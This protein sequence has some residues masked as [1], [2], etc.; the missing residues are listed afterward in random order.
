MTTNKEQKN[1]SDLL[2]ALEQLER[3][4]NIKREDVFKTITDSLVSALRKYFG[5]TAQIMAGI[6][7]ETGEMAGFLVRK[8]TDPVVTPELEISLEEAQKH[9]PDAK[10]GDDIHIPVPIQDFSRIAAQTAKQVLIQK[11]RE[12]EKVRVYDE[13]KPREGE[14][15]TGLVHHV[16][17][18]D[19]FVDLG[20]A[21]AILPFSEQI[22]REHFSVNQ[23][24]RAIIHRVDKENKGLQIVLSR[25]SGAFLKALFEAE[26]PEIAE[27]VIE[28]VDVV[29]DPGFRAKVLV[30]SNSPKVDPV[31]ACVGIR[32]SRIR[33]IMSELANEKIDL[34]PY[35][36]DTLTMIAKSFSPATVSSVKILDKENKRAQIIVPDDQLAMAIGREGQNIRLASR[37]TGWEIEVKSEGQRTEETKHT[38]DM[39]MQDLLKIDGIG[40]KV[41][42]TL[43]TMN[44]LDI[45]TVA[46]LT[47]EELCSLEGIGEKTAQKIIAGAKKFLEENPNYGQ[48]SAQEEAPK[49][50]E[51][52]NEPEK[53]EG[54]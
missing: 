54:K 5:K 48:Q 21:E 29:R 45:R 18:R 44:V 39:A 35:I 33:V 41:A 2:L 23:R 27:K 9:Q 38:N 31:G 50:E 28:I 1:K 8:V 6:D 20:K 16:A 24:V 14:V 22:R 11:I 3:E 4:K 12:I 40:A 7:P 53:T 32:G 17:G 10:L 51:V 47:E 49:T 30:R 15:V 34:I 52:K 36:E 37:L 46:G 13:Y 42:E 19:I 26:V 25:A 43:I